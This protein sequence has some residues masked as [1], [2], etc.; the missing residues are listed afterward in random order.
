M[1][2]V[3]EKLQY[4]IETKNLIKKAVNEVNPG[5]ITP[6]IPFREYP[7]II[8]NSISYI[9]R[10]SEPVNFTLYANN[11]VGNN[12]LL[13]T[14]AE[15][16]DIE[17]V[18]YLDIPLETST[19]NKDYV[20][21]SA[22]TLPYYTQSYNRFTDSKG[23][24]S[25]NISASDAP[26]KD[27]EIA[28]YGLVP[29]TKHPLNPFTYTNTEGTTNVGLDLYIIDGEDTT[30][31]RTSYTGAYIK[32]E[33]IKFKITAYSYKSGVTTVSYTLKVSVGGTQVVNKTSS[34]SDGSSYTTD[35]ISVPSDSS[36]IVVTI[37]TS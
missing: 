8:K 24:V 28:V 4:A 30:E 9:Y 20:V 7:E 11:W 2:T 29:Y 33:Q 27:V 6:E 16:Y 13:E 18:L 17:K 10:I 36:S 25:M 21:E 35:Y 19:V 3:I 32:N 5:A 26:A 37:T 23:V 14:P 15:T 1:S 34:L 31:A 12:Y 22:V